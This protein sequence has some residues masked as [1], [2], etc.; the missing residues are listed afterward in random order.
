MA[1]CYTAVISEVKP[2]SK[3]TAQLNGGSDQHKAKSI[4]RYFSRQS[5]DFSQ[6]DAKIA[7]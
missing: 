5:S 7:K 1:F 4:V 6:E 3:Q 2:K